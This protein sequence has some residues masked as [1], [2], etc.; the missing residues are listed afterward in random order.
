MDEVF[1]EYLSPQM[2]T[3]IIDER[4]SVIA[5]DAYRTQLQMQGLLA[6]GEEQAAAQHSMLLGQLR[7]AAHTLKAERTRWEGVE[8]GHG[9]SH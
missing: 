8:E 1:E 9:H 6:Q 7:V 5:Q 4:L 3:A 2:K